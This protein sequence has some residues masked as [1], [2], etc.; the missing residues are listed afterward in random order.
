MANHFSFGAYIPGNSF[1]HTMSAQVKIFLTCAFSI[2]VFFIET[3]AGLALVAGAIAAL[4]GASGIRLSKG[5]RGVAPVAF[6]LL[7]TV[8]VHV[9]SFTVAGLL[10]GLFI[11]A[12]IALLVLACMLLTFTTSATELTGGLLS[13]LGPLRRAKAPVDDLALVIS[14]SLRFIPITS[15]EAYAIRKA[16]MARCGDFEDGNVLARTKAWGAVL[17]PL[18]VRLFRRAEDL[19]RAMDAR[20][21]GN[22]PRTRP[23][24]GRV[25]GSS[26][27]GMLATLLALVLL[28][29]FL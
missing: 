4:Y 3:W 8:L 21:Y 22:G 23:T 14:L 11:A 20:C 5:L 9:L 26:I 16:Q 24:G 6:V 18:F 28:C 12:R 15:D 29:W 7:F 27:I 10:D 25:P 19:A 13:L 17:V 1:L 2:S